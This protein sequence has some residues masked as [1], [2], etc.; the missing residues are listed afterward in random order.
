MVTFSQL[1]NLKYRSCSDFKCSFFL[2]TK[3][4]E[5]RTSGKPVFGKII[6]VKP[7]SI[8]LIFNWS[9]KSTSLRT[10]VI[11]HL[12]TFLPNLRHRLPRRLSSKDLICQCRRPW[13]HLWVEKIPW[14]RKW[15]PTPVP[16]PGESHGQRSLAGYSPGGHND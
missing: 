9:I 8:P 15:Q 7:M 10:T 3:H 1:L 4:D 2:V 5:S 6:I 12:E 14:R 16:L 13:F 11:F